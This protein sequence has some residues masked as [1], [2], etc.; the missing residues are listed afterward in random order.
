MNIPEY[1]REKEDNF[2]KW[3]GVKPPERTSH[4]ITADSLQEVLDEN[5][6]RHQCQYVQRGATISCDVGGF[7]HGKMIGVTK[8]LAPDYVSG[9]P[10]LVDI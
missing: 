10:V 9:E 4:G 3:K 7:E 8:R 5:I 6:K 1:Q 2:Y